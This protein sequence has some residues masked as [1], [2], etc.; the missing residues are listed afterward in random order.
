M[1]SLSVPN[2]CAKPKSSPGDGLSILVFIGLV[3]LLVPYAGI[4]S[5]SFGVRNA[6]RS[7]QR[8][9]SSHPLE[10][11]IR[12][13]HSPRSSKSQKGKVDAGSSCR[14]AAP[15]CSS[16]KMPAFSFGTPALTAALKPS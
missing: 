1:P 16:S 3:L 8:C 6:P 12:I 7:R 4:M 14:I 2:G 9:G 11:R 10:I 5:H 13:E 15:N